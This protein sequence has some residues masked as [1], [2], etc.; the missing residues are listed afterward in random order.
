MGRKIVWS[1]TSIKQLEK[2]H[3]FVYKE[4]HSLI[5]S[6]NLVNGILDA[7]MVLINQP[8]LYPIDKYR[9][10]NNGSYRAFEVF[11]YRIAYREFKHTIRILQVRHTSRKP[12]N[13]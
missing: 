4:T 1:R 13:Y 3:E 5:I 11:N 2:I 9:I 8:D 7:T 6:D 10:Q 12:L